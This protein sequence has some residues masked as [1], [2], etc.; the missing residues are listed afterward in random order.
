[1]IFP[2]QI[3]KRA[4]YLIDK[5]CYMTKFLLEKLKTR[6]EDFLS[7]INPSLPK[8][9]SYWH[10]FFF[11][12][13]SSCCTLWCWE[14]VKFSFW[15]LSGTNKTTP[16]NNSPSIHEII[17]QKTDK[18]TKGINQHCLFLFFTSLCVLSDW[19]RWSFG[20]WYRGLHIV[21]SPY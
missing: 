11:P 14:L 16:S 9:S 3:C 19:R 15:M 7:F 5:Q 20:R 13:W 17:N 4:P 21:F 12:K 18:M 6:F 8:W 2:F 10:Q 1:M